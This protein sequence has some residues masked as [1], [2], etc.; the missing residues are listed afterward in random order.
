MSQL[1]EGATGF[2]WVDARDATKHPTMSKT[3]PHHREEGVRAQ[4]VADWV[5]KVSKNE[6]KDDQEEPYLS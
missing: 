2:S 4:L 6:A 1:G 3:G 5:W